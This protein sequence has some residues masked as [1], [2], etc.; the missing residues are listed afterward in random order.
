MNKLIDKMMTIS[1]IHVSPETAH[2]LDDEL[3]VTK[4]GLIVYE[5][6]AYGWFINLG[7]DELFNVPLDLLH[8]INYALENGC[9]WLCLDRDG[10]VADDLLTY[11]W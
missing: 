9:S 6:S 1:T 4:W 3:T 7:F 2:L 5:K 8:C 10:D 11:D